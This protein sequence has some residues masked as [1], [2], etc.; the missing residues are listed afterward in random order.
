MYNPNWPQ[1]GQLIDGD[2]FRAQFAGI[3]DL[4]QAGGGVVSAQIDSVTTGNP[5]DPATVGVSLSGATLHFTFGLPRGADGGQGPAGNNGSDGATGPP[6]AS[7]TNGNDGA[8][9]VP[10]NNGINGNDGAQGPPG[11]Q[12]PPFAAALVD[13]TST[14]DPGNA[15]TVS[16]SFDGSNV[17][18][19]FGIPR[20]ADGINGT[21]GND[22]EVSNA[23][24]ASAIAGTSMNS[25]AVST[26]DTVPS[27]P[28]TFADYEA[29][30]A[31]VNELIVALR[32][33]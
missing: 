11:P 31:K 16:V 23:Q 17:R 15:A 22:G 5:G 13:G 21:N 18:F 10:G 25:N 4:I 2:D 20:G 8:Q 19:L 28:P 1:N 29:L 33:V 12:G 7:G 27:D 26:L 3:V 9:G 32:R 14:L 30:R 24:L 6:G